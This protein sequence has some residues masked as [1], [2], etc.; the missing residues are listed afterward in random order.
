M[1]RNISLG[2]HE[3]KRKRE[4]KK[5]K[6]KERAYHSD[7]FATWMR[8]VLRCATTHKKCKT[9]LSPS[10]QCQVRQWLFA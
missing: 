8:Y 4:R 2:T 9:N 1:R 6:E 10:R 5:K 3:K 7:A